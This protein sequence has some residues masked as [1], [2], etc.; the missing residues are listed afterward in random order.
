MQV[1]LSASEVSSELCVQTHGS[2]RSNSSRS[3]SL[4]ERRVRFAASEV[5]SV[6]TYDPFA[7]RSSGNAEHRGDWTPGSVVVAPAGGLV[8]PSQ[9]MKDSEEDE[10]YVLYGFDV[11]VEGVVVHTV[12]ERYSKLREKARSAARL[13]GGLPPFPPRRWWRDNTHTS[14]HVSERSRELR[15]WLQ[16]VVSASLEPCSASGSARQRHV[17]A[18]KALGIK[19]RS[20]AARMMREAADTRRDIQSGVPLAEILARQYDTS[21]DGTVSPVEEDGISDAPS[22]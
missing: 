1:A 8:L 20:L 13:C 7:A 2:L 21:S 16:K 3:S 6:A 11:V 15:S 10:A 12:V 18:C 17:A 4:S 22:E 14:A 9:V 19:R 5:T